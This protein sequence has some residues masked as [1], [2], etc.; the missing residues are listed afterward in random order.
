MKQRKPKGRRRLLA[1]M[2][3]AVLLGGCAAPQMKPES[4][5]AIVPPPPDV[6]AQVRAAGREADDGIDVTPLRDPV[7]EDLRERAA[8]Q[9]AARDYARAEAALD[10]ALRLVPG[11]PE[12]L[13]WRAELALARGAFDEAVRLAGDSWE[14]GPRLGGLCRRSWAVIRVARELTGYPDAAA[15][16]QAQL[17]RCT[18]APPVRM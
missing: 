8:R 17:A 14:R 1:T 9:E 12:L 11:D 13:Q 15:A 2:A 7:V 4:E 3:A 10:E 16:A 6:L 18:V 5:A